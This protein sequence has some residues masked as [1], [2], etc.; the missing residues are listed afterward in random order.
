ML[1]TFANIQFAE[2]MKD[3]QVKIHIYQTKYNDLTIHYLG[4]PIVTP[5]WVI[6]DGNLYIGLF[7]QVVASAAGHVAAKGKSIL[8]NEQFTD[9]RKPGRREP[10]HDQRLQLH[11]PAAHRRPDA[12]AQWAMISRLS[13][14]A[15]LFGVQSPPI[16]L[17][18]LGKLLPHLAPAGS[19]SWTDND[20]VHARGVSPFPGAT[21]LGTDPMGGQMLLPAM[22]GALGEGRAEIRPRRRRASRGSAAREGGRHPRADRPAGAGPAAA[23]FTSALLPREHEPRE[24]PAPVGS[25]GARPSRDDRYRASPGQ[26]VRPGSIRVYA[27]LAGAVI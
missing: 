13:G 18:P 11:G 12:Y 19:V 25:A 6:A 9:L 4:T 20:G 5:S 1:E 2:Q 22:M 7:P 10:R 3:E 24:R 16:L 17:P 15:D 23:G 26:V 21:A 8:D 27:T 14:F